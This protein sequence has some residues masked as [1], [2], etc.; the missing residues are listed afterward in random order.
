MGLAWSCWR[1][2]EN[3]DDGVSIKYKTE[4]PIQFKQYL[5]YIFFIICSIHYPSWRR[6]TFLRVR[7]RNRRFLPHPQKTGR[8][9]GRRLNKYKI[10]L[11]IIVYV[12][13]LQAAE[14]NHAATNNVITYNNN[15]YTV[16]YF[17]ME[18][19]FAYIFYTPTAICEEFSMRNASDEIF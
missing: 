4:T 1:G 18:K 15:S 16:I 5:Q 2:I 19:L 6:Y 9:Y 12:F 10:V 13:I 14:C 3:R 11:L 8:R 7:K 17:H